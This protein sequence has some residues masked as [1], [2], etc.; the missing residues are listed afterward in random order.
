[1]TRE[2]RGKPFRLC[3]KNSFFEI[4]ICNPFKS[5]AK[6]GL[7]TEKGIMNKIM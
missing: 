6:G 1:M 4:N 3:R 5:R 7:R 2:T